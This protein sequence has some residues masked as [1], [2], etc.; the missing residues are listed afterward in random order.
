MLKITTLTKDY[1]P[2]I[3]KQIEGATANVFDDVGAL[4]MIEDYKTHSTS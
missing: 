4:F 3:G 2:P 1:F